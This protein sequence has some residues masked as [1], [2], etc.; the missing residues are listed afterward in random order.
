M[1]KGR[2]ALSAALGLVLAACG[3]IGFKIKP[4]PH[5]GIQVCAE[6]LANDPRQLGALEKAIL[7]STIYVRPRTLVG[8]PTDTSPDLY[9]FLEPD[10]TTKLAVYSSKE[11][12]VKAL[13]NGRYSAFTGNALRGFNAQAP[14]VLN[15]GL[16]STA[17]VE[18]AKGQFGR[19]ADETL[20][21]LPRDCVSR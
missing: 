10:G 5:D 4:Q 17:A 19:A 15:Y 8:A 21:A 20:P 13:G 6:R 18:W 11:N 14:I 16:G 12:L 2:A 9:Q 1:I 7:E 3:P